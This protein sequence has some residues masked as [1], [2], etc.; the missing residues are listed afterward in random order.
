MLLVTSG[1]V[2][3]DELAIAKE[4]LEAYDG[5]WQRMQ[6]CGHLRILLRAHTGLKAL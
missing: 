5:A 6:P 3:L 2:I 4:L 1:T